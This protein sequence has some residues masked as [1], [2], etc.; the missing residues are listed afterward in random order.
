V[1]DSPLVFLL[2]V[3]VILL[4]VGMFMETNAATLLMG[5]LLAPTA[6]QYGIDPIHFA[7]ILVTNIELGLLTPPLAANLYVAARTNRV[8]IIDLLR[9]LGWF[10]VACLVMMAVITYVPQVSLWY[11]LF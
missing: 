8:P 1:T 9:H 10:L 6:V 2:I 11:R 7:I 4:V 3:N 5:P